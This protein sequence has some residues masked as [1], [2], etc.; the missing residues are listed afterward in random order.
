VDLSSVMGGGERQGGGECRG[1]GGGG[2][3]GGEQ[4]EQGGYVDLS[5]VKCRHVL[6]CKRIANYGGVYYLATIIIINKELNWR[7]RNIRQHT[8][9]P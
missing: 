7:L 9:V 6:G 3:G 8:S 5:S 2:G 4:G 1:G